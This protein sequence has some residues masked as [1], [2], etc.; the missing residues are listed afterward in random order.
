MARPLVWVTL[1]FMGGLAA[2]GW[3]LT[4]PGGWLPAGLLILWVLLVL[5]WWTRPRAG[6]LALAFFCFLG[7]AF[8]QQAR[9][10][11]F[12]PPH[13][14]DLPLKEEL[15]LRARLERPGKTGAQGVQMLVD[16]TAWRSPGGWRPVSGQLLLTA[17]PLKTPP[18]GASLI[19]K[20]RLRSPRVLKNPGTFDRARYLAA[21]G[22]FRVASLRHPGDLIVLAN[23]GASPL[24]ERL[25]GSIRRLLEEL[26]PVPRA[27]YLALLLGDQGEITQKMRQAFS[28]TGASHLLVISGMHLGAVAAVAYFLCFWGLRCFPRLLL[29]INAL[30]V[31][32]LVAAVPVVAYA[33]MAGGSPATQRA[34][35]MVLACLLLLFLGRPREVWSALALA[36]LLIL[37]LSPL[38]LYTISFQLSFTAVAGILYFLPRWFHWDWEDLSF[39]W[40]LRRWGIKSWRWCKEAAVVSV[41][42]TL[43]TAPLVAAYFQ[44]V[45]LLGA[46]VNLVAIPLV[47]LLALPLGEAAVL[48]QSLHLTPVAQILLALG[49]IPLWLAYEAVAAAAR[50]PG[51][52]FICATPTWWQIAAYFLLWVMLFPPRRRWWTWTGA[53]LAG[54]V[55][56]GTISLPG[57]LAPKD[58]EVT[59]LD[60]GG[61]LAGVA[62]SPEGQRLVFSAPGPSWPGQGGGGPGPLPDYL[63]W[64]QW[65]RLDEVMALN[66]AQGNAPE[67]LALARQ[68]QVG[69]FWFGRRGPQGP[70]CYEFINLLGDERRSPR[71]LERGNPPGTLGS[72]G[73]ALRPLGGRGVALQLSY[74]GRVV[75]ILP[76]GTRLP[77]GEWNL[78]PGTRLAALFISGK[79]APDLDALAGSL[80][81]EI[82]IIYGVPPEGLATGSLPPGGR[83]LVTAAGAV[84]LRISAGGAD[85]RQW[86]PGAGG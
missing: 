39:H 47:L 67:L 60:T 14:I 8:Y 30:Q 86:R 77:G 44:V 70:A 28:R 38:R 18:V 61:A 31:S 12:P 74:Q 22:I 26:P 76:P 16:V 9:Q 58:L 63:H 2:P 64:R 7:V 45:S 43:A 55:L 48:A 71:S 46:A 10:P 3:G 56:V 62:V 34:E 35:I 15:T 27:M 82:I 5:A 20:T 52:A 1:A 25:R 59:C 73:L 32:T 66:L 29:R 42:A 53:A 65:R 24:R 33:W 72:V 84:S 50:L 51:S 11:F 36:A 75:L 83:C 37:C 49:Q 40:W 57:L 13:L 81:P 54:L 6:W 78:P 41:V 21:D 4:I 23:A 69:Q 68:F 85:V 19:L 79:P 17:P 80:H